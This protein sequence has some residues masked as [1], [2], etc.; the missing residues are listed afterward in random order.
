MYIIDDMFKAIRAIAEAVKA[1]YDY[2]NLSMQQKHDSMNIHSEIATSL[3]DSIH[4]Y[5]SAVSNSISMYWI[6]FQ[7]S[8]FFPES[9]YE[10]SKIKEIFQGHKNLHRE[11][12]DKVVSARQ[13]LDD[14]ISV[15]VALWDEEMQSI[16]DEM[17]E[18]EETTR[19]RILNQLTINNP[20]ASR[21]EK[22]YA[23][24]ILEGIKLDPRDNKLVNLAKKAERTL[25]RK[26]QLRNT[27]PK[28]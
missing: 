14:D 27:N 15:A 10:P 4:R 11:R 21:S 16:L 17:I 9:K 13:E 26:V 18:I 12:N 6:L 5:K 24:Q 2:K 23:K 7:N 8:N 28:P 20:D 3:I 22:E 25:K 1:R 19:K